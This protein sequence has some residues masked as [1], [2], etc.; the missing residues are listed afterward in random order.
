MCV[1]NGMTN[2]HE[3]SHQLSQFRPTRFSVGEILRIMQPCQRLAQTVAANE[4][5]D[6]ERSP[7]IGLTE[8]VDRNDSRMLQPPRH[9]GFDE[10]STSLF[11]VTCEVILDLLQGHLPVQFCVFGH[12]HFADPAASV[13]T[14]NAKTAAAC[15][16][17]CVQL[18]CAVRVGF[19]G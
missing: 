18:D 5:H 13:G 14:Q 3:A 1:C 17:G 4:L 8:A 10:E 12:G 15:A 2:V 19:H 16:A 7:R 11:R 6:V 9:F